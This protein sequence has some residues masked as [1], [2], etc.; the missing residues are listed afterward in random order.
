M[1][2]SAVV[3]LI[4]SAASGCGIGGGGLLVVYMTMYLD[5]TQSIA[6]ATN[7]LLFI[8]SS[9]TSAWLQHRRQT[10]PNTKLILFCSSL[11]LPGVFLG[12]FLRDKLSETSLRIFF[13]YLLVIA[14]VSVLAKLAV[15]SLSVKKKTK[16]LQ[17]K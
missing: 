13:G 14:G 1:L 17:K 4:I 10:L 2:I 11:S 9:S 5:M 7:L 12:T 8:L 16:N 6:Q 15:K 3:T